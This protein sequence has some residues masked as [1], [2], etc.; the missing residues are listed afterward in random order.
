MKY[1]ED[2]QKINHRSLSHHPTPAVCWYTKDKGNKTEVD[3]N[4]GTGIL[5][6]P[7]ARA[8]GTRGGWQLLPSLH[9]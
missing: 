5:A 7:I 8:I 2:Q 1:E 4:Y 3:E 9:S 6:R